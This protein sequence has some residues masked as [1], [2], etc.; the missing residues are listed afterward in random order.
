[1][2]RALERLDTWLQ[3]SR[4]LGASRHAANMLPPVVSDAIA[5]NAARRP[6]WPLLRRASALASCSCTVLNL[7]AAEW[8]VLRR[9]EVTCTPSHLADRY[10]C[11]VGTDDLSELILAGGGARATEDA[12][13][14]LLSAEEQARSMRLRVWRRGG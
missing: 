2:P 5:Q 12:T 8:P 6:P 14:E 3:L 10:R 13:S 4:C 9:Q 1:V 7:Q 11:R